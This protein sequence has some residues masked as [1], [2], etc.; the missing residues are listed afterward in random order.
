MNTTDAQQSDF[1]A[2]DESCW[3]DRST[4]TACGTPAGRGWL[5]WGACKD[6]AVRHAA[7]HNRLTMDTYG[8]LLPGAEAEAA[9]QDRT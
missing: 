9:D 5:K 1:L 2:A 6:G 4:S 3:S 8:H 7:F